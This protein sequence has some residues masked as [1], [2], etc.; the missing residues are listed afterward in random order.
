MGFDAFLGNPQDTIL[1]M[2]GK[3]YHCIGYEMKVFILRISL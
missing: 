1:F 2:G 3:D